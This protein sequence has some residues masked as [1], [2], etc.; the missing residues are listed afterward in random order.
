MPQPLRPLSRLR[1]RL[2]RAGRDSGALSLELAIV[3]PLVMTVI[4]AAIQAGLWYHARDVALSAA[5]RGVETARVQ[6]YGIDQGIA[7]ATG[8]LDR[9]GGSIDSRTVSG[10]DGATVRIDVTGRVD[11]WIPGLSLPISQHASAP[12][13]RVTAT[14]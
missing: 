3:F 7:V 9:A 2:L 13:E 6:G 12:R 4:F 5:Q 10:S 1:R 11:T 14:R 8:F